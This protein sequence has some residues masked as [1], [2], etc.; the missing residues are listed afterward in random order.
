LALYDSSQEGQVVNT[1][2]NGYDDTIKLQTIQAI[3]LAI[4][5]VEETCS[6]ITGVFRERLGG[7]EQRDA[8]TNVQVGVKN[9]SFIT[10]Q[11]Y[12]VMD[13]V[14]RE[15]LLDILNIS[16]IV[17]KDGLSGTLILGEKLN[18]IFTALPEHFAVSDHDIHIAD[19]SEILKEEETIKQLVAELS[20]AGIADIEIIIEAITS[21]SLT[22]L[23]SQVLSALARK[24]QENDQTGQLMQQA[25]EMQK[26]LKEAEATINKLE[27]NIKRL[28]EEKLKL[29]YAKLEHEKEIG[30]FKAKSDDEYKDQKI[31]WEKKRVQLEGIQLLDHN[32]NN[33]EIKNK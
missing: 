18:K 14:T 6:N 21:K 23:K 10:K 9:S 26:Q 20:K 12:Q 1:A 4:Q 3:D 29:E 25:E 19:S 7:I 17:Y 28:S 27:A 22:S 5:R 31:E 33:D 13:L 2:F 16:K 15:I 30:W 11:Y 32:P 8:V 24:K